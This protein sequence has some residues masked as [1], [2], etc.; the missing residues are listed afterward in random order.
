MS[1]FK[2]R[3][4]VVA[5]AVTVGLLTGGGVAWGKFVSSGFASASGVAGT[6]QQPTATGVLPFGKKLYPG[7][8]RDIRVTVTN[9][10]DFPVTVFRVDKSNLPVTV[11]AAHAAGCVVTGVS[12]T[13]PPY[14]VFWN[15]SANA[16]R[17]F[18]LTDGMRMSNDSQNGCQGA[19]F[20]VPITISA[21]TA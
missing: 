3:R 15:L 18:Q 8:K 6:I 7:V 13:N 21:R 5:A 12:L 9:P 1:R 11:D 10:N 20:T 19:T 14:A 4:L 2:H 16:T 17:T